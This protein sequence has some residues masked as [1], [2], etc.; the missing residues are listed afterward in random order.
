MEGKNK[1]ISQVKNITEELLDS[2]PNSDYI[3]SNENSLPMKLENFIQNNQSEFSKKSTNEED[4]NKSEKKEENINEVK[5]AISSKSSFNSIISEKEKYRIS[6]IF[7]KKNSN[8]SLKKKRKRNGNFK[9][10]GISQNILIPQKKIVQEGSRENSKDKK[11]EPKNI[12]KSKQNNL[13][14]ANLGNNSNI[15]TDKNTLLSNINKISLDDVNNIINIDDNPNDLIS[16]DNNI[17]NLSSNTEERNLIRSDIPQ[18]D[19]DLDEYM[20]YES[21]FKNSNLD[22]KYFSKNE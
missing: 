11:T 17:R 14:L 10:K 18:Q 21:F 8:N 4:S 15:C 22:T 13:N 19:S 2:D 9:K 5:Q 12:G 3:Y 6:I 1:N 7:K 20:L 16:N